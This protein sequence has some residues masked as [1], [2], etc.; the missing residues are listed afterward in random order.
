MYNSWDIFQGDMYIYNIIW[1]YMGLTGFIEL[2][3]CSTG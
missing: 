2:I 3:H 1:D